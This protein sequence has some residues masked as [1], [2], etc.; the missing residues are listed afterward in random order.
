LPLAESRLVASGIR[1]KRIVPIGA[2]KYRENAAATSEPWSI[3]VHGVSQSV[4][5]TTR[6]G[7]S[8]VRTTVPS[9]KCT[10]NEDEASNSGRTRT[11]EG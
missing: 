1:S 7:S 6:A 8:R 11:N 3:P 10:R 4:V 2:F 5:W 9:G